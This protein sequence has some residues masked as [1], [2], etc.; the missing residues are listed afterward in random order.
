MTDRL[1][2]DVEPAAMS[3]IMHP[4]QRIQVAKKTMWQSL[5]SNPKVLFIAFFAS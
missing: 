3:Q 2:S 5:R 4:E 1:S